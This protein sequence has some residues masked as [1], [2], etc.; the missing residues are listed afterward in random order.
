MTTSKRT[1]LHVLPKVEQLDPDERRWQMT[2]SSDR[3]PELVYGNDD[4]EG[5]D[6]ST[7]KEPPEQPDLLLI[8]TEDLD[9]RTATTKGLGSV[10]INAESRFQSRWRE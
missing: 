9:K 3:D 10:V 1:R 4:G 6:D 2:K 7:I 5:S 8:Y